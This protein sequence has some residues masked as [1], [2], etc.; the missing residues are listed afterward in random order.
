MTAKALGIRSRCPLFGRVVEVL[1]QRSD[2][3]LRLA[4]R[5]V[6]RAERDWLAFLRIRKEAADDQNVATCFLFL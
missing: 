4:A 5:S 6:L 1:E 3:L 2:V